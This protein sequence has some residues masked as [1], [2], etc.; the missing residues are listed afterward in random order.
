[1]KQHEQEPMVEKRRMFILLVAFV[2]VY[3]GVCGFLY[4]FHFRDQIRK[5]WDS[6]NRHRQLPPSSDDL[7]HDKE[8][9]T[10]EEYAR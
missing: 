10:V 6:R 3:Y 9:I 1:M 5:W 8:S 7:R 4:F 2:A